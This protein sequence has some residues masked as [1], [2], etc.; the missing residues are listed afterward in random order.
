MPGQPRFLF[1]ILLALVLPA[2]ATLQGDMDPPG[3]TLESLRFL[4][5]ESGSPSTPSP[6]S[7]AIT[8]PVM[9]TFSGERELDFDPAPC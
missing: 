1:V 5:A 2:C 9:A 8:S 7:S 6:V 4:P 3:I